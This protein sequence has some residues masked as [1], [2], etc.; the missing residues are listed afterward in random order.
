MPRYQF[1]NV[2]R[3]PGVP[4]LNRSLQFPAGPPPQLGGVIALG[5][6]LL[7]FLSPPLWGIYRDTSA[8]PV[9]TSADIDPD[10]GL[11]FPEVTVNSSNPAVVVPDSFREFSY[12]S[13][14][15]VSDFPVEQGGFASYNKV[16][17]PYEIMVRMTKGGSLKNRTD[18]LNSIERIA[19]DTNLYK[20]VTPERTYLQVNI[21]RFEVARR[22]APGAYFLSEVD[23]FFRE[24]RQ[25]QSQ[26]S[27]SATNT[28]NALAPGAQ[29]TVNTGTVQPL[30]VP[31]N[32]AAA[33]AAVPPANP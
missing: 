13:E 6:L 19:G 12:R 1:P 5:R 29:P 7:A 20:I 32:I 15:A 22:E 11:P 24:I 18:F 14:Y 4:Q 23:L 3:L 2:P 25:V 10:T 28:Q 9:G 26:Y 30:P 8:D 21:T 31:G 17:A 27:V 33:V 16:A